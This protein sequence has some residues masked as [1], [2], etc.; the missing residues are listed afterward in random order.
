MLCKSVVACKILLVFFMLLFC[1][2]LVCTFMLLY[3]NQF[4]SNKGKIVFV[5]FLIVDTAVALIVNSNHFF[6]RFA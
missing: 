5:E 4:L 6:P 3:L 2:F 1:G